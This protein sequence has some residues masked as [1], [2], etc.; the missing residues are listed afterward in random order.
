MDYSLLLCIE[1]RSNSGSSECAQNRNVNSSVKTFGMV[2]EGT[3]KTEL[4]LSKESTLSSTS[5]KQ[6]QEKLINQQQKT[7]SVG[8]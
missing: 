7:Q 6:L 4:S 2:R 5:I 1:S 8:N 3:V